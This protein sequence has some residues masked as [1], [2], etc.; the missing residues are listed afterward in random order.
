MPTWKIEDINAKWLIIK[1]NALD[2]A[3]SIKEEL[4]EK[5]NLEEYKFEIAKIYEDLL[6]L[7]NTRHY[8]GIHFV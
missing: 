8:E 1:N 2:H 6:L 3:K 7:K 5:A 4:E